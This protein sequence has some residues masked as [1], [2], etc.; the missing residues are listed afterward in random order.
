VDKKYSS[1]Y[2]DYE[3]S[4]WWFLARK[5]ILLE[6]MRLGLRNNKQKRKLLNVGSASGTSSKWLKEF[7]EVISVDISRFLCATAKMNSSEPVVCGALPNLPFSAQAF[8]VICA[9]DTIE[10]VKEYKRSVAELYRILKPEGLLFVTVPAVRALWGSHDVINHHIKRFEKSELPKLFSCFKNLRITYFNFFLFP[11][12]YLFRKC[13]KIK[14]QRKTNFEM[15]G[16]GL[17]KIFYYIFVLEKVFLS[18]GVNFPIGAS[19]L[20]VAQKPKIC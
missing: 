16:K 14:P 17:S 8:E 7:G 4:H 2:K 15:T 10:H 11:L 1:D 18:K 20:V 5:E 12:I 6:T 9:F 13:E 19:L 3:N